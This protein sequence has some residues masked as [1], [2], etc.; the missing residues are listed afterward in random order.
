M[1]IMLK[2]VKRRIINDLY[3][4]IKDNNI[5]TANIPEIL[6]RAIPYID[7]KDELFDALE[8]AISLIINRLKA[9]R[10]Y[11]VNKE[12]ES[13]M[14]AIHNYLEQLGLKM[15]AIDLFDFLYLIKVRDISIIQFKVNN[16]SYT[17]HIS[18]E[19]DG[20]ESIE[21]MGEW[22]R[23]YVSFLNKAKVSNMLLRCLYEDITDLHFE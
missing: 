12:D 18:A 22:Y 5:A 7:N 10:D 21:F 14:I 11:T 4:Q 16:Q 6:I 2:R 17:V 15:P 3:E 9:N 8:R 19:D 23:D 20:T 1:A 13:T